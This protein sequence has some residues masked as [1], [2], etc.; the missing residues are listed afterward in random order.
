MYLKNTNNFKIIP[1]GLKQI[2]QNKFTNNIAKNELIRMR[3]EG[4][5]TDRDLKIA[6]F[7]F[8]F[9]FATLN[10]IQRYLKSNV[11]E[12][13]LKTR[14]EKLIQYRIIN[15]FI[16]SD[17]EDTH[18]Q[19]DGLV[20]YCLDIGGKYILTNYSTEDTCDWS[21]ANNMKTS[22]NI[23]KDLITLEFYLKVLENCPNKLVFFNANP[24]LRNGRMTV[25]PS[26]EMCLNIDGEKRYFIG[27]IARAYDVPENYRQKAI[28][29]EKIIITNAWR[30]YYIGTE[31]PPILFVFGDNDLS[32]LDLGEI[33]NSVT[34]IDTFRLSTFDRFANL[35]HLEDKTL[36]A[37]GTFLK[38]L[39]ESKN[40]KMVNL[41]QFFLP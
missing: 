17:D 15:K 3:N 10:Q 26:F 38:Y 21:V 20:I 4:I 24:E 1:E 41:K 37:K 6:K 18:V 8:K 35:E 36:S 14:L 5:I 7:L 29:L 40:L 16:L 9:K 34:R 13:G 19:A 22:E 31:K 32:A 11:S 39:P 33:T 30:K 27:E 23:S 12:I 28:K 2:F 25:I